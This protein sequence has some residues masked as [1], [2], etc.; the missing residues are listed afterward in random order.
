MEVAGRLNAI[1]IVRARMVLP[2]FD[3]RILIKHEIVITKNTCESLCVRYFQID[4]VPPADLIT[5][6][7]GDTIHRD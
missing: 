7:A 3:P 2:R 6:R 1:E 5:R 4:L